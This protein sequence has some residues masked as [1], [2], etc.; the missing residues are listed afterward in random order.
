MYFLV[1]FVFSLV[2][3]ASLVPP[4]IEQSPL[5]TAPEILS[6]VQDSQPQVRT[7]EE[8]LH[9]LPLAY[10]AHFVLQYDSHSNHSSNPTHPRVIFFGPDAK[11]LLAFSGL[12][13]D[14]FYE[15]VEMIEYE[16]AK[17]SYSFYSI[18]FQENSQAEVE[19]NPQDCLRC[20]G[21]DPKPNWEPF[22]LWPGTFGSLHDKIL[23]QTKEHH[24]FEGFLKTYRN[25]PRYQYLPGP[26][27]MGSNSSLSI[28]LGFLNRDRM[29]KKLVATESHERYRPAFTAALLGCDQP[30]E[31]FLPEDLKRAHPEKFEKVLNET[32][33]FMEKD[34]ARKKRAL[35]K[36]LAVNEEFIS[37]HADLSG[38]RRSEVQRIAKLRYLLAGRIDNP[39][40]FDRWA[41]SISKTSLDFNDGVG[42]LENLIGHYLMLAYEEEEPVRKLTPLR[43]VAF[44]TASTIQTYSL[45]DSPSSVCELLAKEAKALSLVQ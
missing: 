45:T 16:P 32:I 29:A 43:E 11:L 7:V 10:R 22:S 18:H 2:S 34:L 3:S 39:V 13:T 37:L 31:N 5:L 28:L 6:W 27:Q 26:F 41:L 1:F 12:P 30:I 23:P 40:N 14:S 36:Y 44:S 8:L 19:I 25:S 38:F 35:M 20:H 21:T 42:G 17:A 15:T 4:A 24:F 9:Q 33:I